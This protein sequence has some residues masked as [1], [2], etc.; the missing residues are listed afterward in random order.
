M[1]G[2]LGEEREHGQSPGEAE[3]GQG[4]EQKHIQGL[5]PRVLG[6]A[7]GLGRD[8]VCD[9]SSGWLRLSRE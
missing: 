6:E 3:T 9:H 8:R 7:R 1:M 2:A 4:R 5:E